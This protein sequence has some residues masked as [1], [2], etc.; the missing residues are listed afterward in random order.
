MKMEFRCFL[1]FEFGK[2]FE[3]HVRN[4]IN[5]RPTS[6]DTGPLFLCFFFVFHRRRRQRQCHSRY[7]SYFVFKIHKNIFQTSYLEMSIAAIPSRSS[8]PSVPNRN[9]STLGWV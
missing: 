6:V 8:V 5:V 4:E 9:R 7:S 3:E 1:F 2:A